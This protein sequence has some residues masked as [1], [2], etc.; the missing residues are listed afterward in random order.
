M[1]NKWVNETILKLDCLVC[2]VI[3]HMLTPYI[4]VMSIGFSVH[5]NLFYQM[6]LQYDNDFKFN[7]PKDRLRPQ[8]VS[9]YQY[10]LREFSLSIIHLSKTTQIVCLRHL[11]L[12]SW[13]LQRESESLKT[14]AFKL[15]GTMRLS[16]Y[17][18]NFEGRPCVCGLSGVF[19]S[20]TL[21]PL[22]SH[23]NRFPSDPY[24]V[25]RVVVGLC[26]SPSK[27]IKNETDW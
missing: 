9:G 4:S 18:F 15:K 20:P 14:I 8:S 6:Y 17:A 7:N 2:V 1:I 24:N 22:L 19:Y 11:F 25:W 3:Y 13:F 12:H 21:L 10:S 23:V 5:R 26:Y 16:W 27:F